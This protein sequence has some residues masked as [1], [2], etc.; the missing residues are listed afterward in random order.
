MLWL[1]YR[2]HK[3]AYILCRPKK[4]DIR[5]LEFRKNI[6]NF[7]R[8]LCM[9]SIKLHSEKFHFHTGDR[10]AVLVT[11]RN[12]YVEKRLESVFNVKQFGF[13]YLMQ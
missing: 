6:L 2:M 11:P 7:R 1:F 13:I 12:T 8:E 4:Q 10:S 5:L 9:K 3:T